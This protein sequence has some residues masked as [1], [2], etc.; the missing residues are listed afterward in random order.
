M[1]IGRCMRLINERH[2]H[3]RG[4]LVGHGARFEEIGVR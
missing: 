2:I 1:P 4:S 3:M